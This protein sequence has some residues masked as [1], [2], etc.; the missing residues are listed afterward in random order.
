ML[1][2]ITQTR[3]DNYMIDHNGMISSEYDTK[4]Q[5]KWNNVWSMTKT[6]HDKDVTD[7]TSELYAENETKLS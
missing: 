1:R 7:R 4:Y 6:R 3:Q 2:L 5:D